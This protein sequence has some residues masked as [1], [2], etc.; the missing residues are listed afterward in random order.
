MCEWSLLDNIVDLG[1]CDESDVL[2][3]QLV[4][5]KPSMQANGRVSTLLSAMD[6]LQE[7][8]T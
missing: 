1:C 4:L 2:H 6:V 8:A 3:Y 7:H 5:F